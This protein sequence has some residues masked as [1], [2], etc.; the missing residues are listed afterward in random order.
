ME[1][2]AAILHHGRRSG[3]QHSH[4]P[5][6]TTAHTDLRQ[7]MQ[8]ETHRAEK[9]RPRSRRTYHD[10]RRAGRLP[11]RRV[12]FLNTESGTRTVRFPATIL[13]REAR[14]TERTARRLRMRHRGDTA[15]C[16]TGRQR[17]GNKQR[18]GCNCARN[19]ER[20][21]RPQLGQERHRMPH[22]HARTDAHDRRWMARPVR[23]T[24]AG[25]EAAH[26]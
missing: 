16:H 3:S 10:I 7:T 26:Y 6:R 22:T 4:R 15:I 17:T 20:L 9:H 1:R 24:A 2:H 19:T 13:Q 18:P 12:T 23:R 14:I 11:P 25:R 21:L 8:G 5:Q